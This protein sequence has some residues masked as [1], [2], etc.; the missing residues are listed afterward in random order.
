MSSGDRFDSDGADEIDAPTPRGDD[1]SDHDERTWR[2]ILEVPFVAAVTGGSGSGKSVLSHRLL[3]VFG[4]G[5]VGLDPYVAGFPESR[6]HLLPEHY[7][8]L[9][10]TELLDDHGDNYAEIVR[11]WPDNSIVLLDVPQIFL[12]A[13]RSDAE[14]RDFFDRLARVA[15]D[16]DTCLVFEADTT[17]P[18]NDATVA[19][20]DAFLV[21]YPSETQTRFCSEEVQDV[22]EA[23]RQALGEYVD[24]ENAGEY[25]VR[26]RTDELRQH[27]Y[28]DAER[29][30]GEYPHR[31]QLP[32]YWDDRISRPYTDI[33][34]DTDKM[35]DAEDALRAIYAVR[36]QR[37]TTDEWV[38]KS[39]IRREL[40][41]R[42]DDFYDSVLPAALDELV[43]E[44]HCE[45][46]TR[47][48]EEHY[49][50][51]A[52]GDREALTFEGESPT[53]G[54]PPHNEMVRAVVN[55]LTSVGF[56]ADV[57][58]QDNTGQLPDG[59]ADVPIDMTAESRSE[60]EAKWRRLD[61]Q[62]P[63]IAAVTDGRGLNIEAETG[64]N[65][66]KQVIA[67]LRSA[68]EQNRICLFCVP[69]GD[70]DPAAHARRLARKLCSPACKKKEVEGEERL[71]HDTEKL[72]IHDEASIAVRDADIPQTQWW[73]LTSD[74]FEL[75]T[76]EDGDIVC[77][78]PAD[79]ERPEPDAEHAPAFYRCEQGRYRVEWIDDDHTYHSTDYDS[80]EAF[81]DEWTV[82]NRPF[83]PEHH[84]D[85]Y[86]DIA[87]FW[88]IAVVP[89][90]P[91]EPLYQYN[92][93]VTDDGGVEGQLEP[94]FDVDDG[95]YRTAGDTDHTDHFRSNSESHWCLYALG[96]WQDDPDTDGLP[97]S[98]ELYEYT[99]SGDG[100]VFADVPDQSPF[101]SA[102]ALST[103]PSRL[104]RDTDLV[105]RVRVDTHHRPGNSRYAYGLTD[106]G[107][108]ALVDAGV[109][110]RLPAL[111]GVCRRFDTS[112]AYDPRAA[113]T[114][115]G[116]CPICGAPSGDVNAHVAR[117]AG[118]DPSHPT[119]ISRNTV[120]HWTLYALSH[121]VGRDGAATAADVYEHA[122]DTDVF[123]GRK[124]ASTALS[125]IHA[126]GLVDRR[127]AADTRGHAY[128]LNEVGS[129]Y[130]DALGRPEEKPDRSVEGFE[131][132]LDCP[133]E[134]LLSE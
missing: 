37:D 54:K 110:N 125:D 91:D 94:M 68:I 93:R 63:R 83:V 1:A 60:M 62:W 12:H 27:V 126:V 43:S 59:T 119:P 120:A 92:T 58:D 73:R 112:P 41:R 34:E 38:S 71:Y 35:V 53:T 3:E 6:S 80:K 121:L 105:R 124:S 85:E 19:A 111:D 79:G 128:T 88:R 8:T 24:E 102:N 57:E 86:Q 52:S 106:D 103:I 99:T 122:S 40:E 123:A 134:A 72:H 97:T 116:E 32:D 115:E 75:R 15:R 30:T 13:G 64:N 22:F 45:R 20:I 47:D 14:V 70:D 114:I 132:R 26:S 21:R 7:D 55:R 29:F 17:E 5:E 87:D 89:D 100:L 81:S 36:L 42:H 108:C 74:D 9:S 51:T 101:S 107:W 95:T 33:D 44:G 65:G 118:D 39:E 96:A 98:R 113:S 46:A 69:E 23:A 49:R 67:N 10:V 11:Q 2:D 25:T 77:R 66:S 56:I 50:L 127:R 133:P 61:E 117:H 131:T 82:I 78:I 130:L 90:D 16:T 4:D 84:I 18:L 109:P 48:D 104:C 129:R 31:V 76:A 28:V